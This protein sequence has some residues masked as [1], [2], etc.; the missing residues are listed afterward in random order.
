[1]SPLLWSLKDSTPT[2][3]GIRHS[4]RTPNIHS[5]PSQP[6]ELMPE[7]LSAGSVLVALLDEA[8]GEFSVPSKVLSCLCVGR[9]VLLSVP[10]RNAAARI[11][12]ENYAGLVTAPGD[13]AAFVCA[14]IRLITTR[15]F[16]RAAAQTPWPSHSRLS[17]Y[18]LL[19]AGSRK[20]ADSFP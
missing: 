18:S 8:A 15:N 16:A 6:Y 19:P 12:R 20:S 5:L 7:V 10:A 3:F 11:V 14:A 13:S 9:P 17:I 1:M 4:A 2:G